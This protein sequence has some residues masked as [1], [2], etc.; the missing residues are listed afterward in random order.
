MSANA[1]SNNGGGRKLKAINGLNSHISNAEKAQREKAEKEMDKFPELSDKPP[2]YLD[3]LAKRVW[4]ELAPQIKKLPIKDLDSGIF[5]QYCNFYQHYVDAEKDIKKNGFKTEDGSKLSPSFRVMKDSADSMRKCA[6]EL[7][8]TV[9]SRLRLL[10]P[11]KDD[12]N[13][14]SLF[15]VFGSGK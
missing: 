1:G 13:R 8:L 7:G 2:A 14:E 6:S 10:I 12:E 9:D 3:S 5:E 4:K 15:D 11:N